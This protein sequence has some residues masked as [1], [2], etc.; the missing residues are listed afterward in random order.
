MER[1]LIVCPHCNAE[2]LPAEIYM[3][4]S[5]LGRPYDIIK[6]SQGKII[7]FSGNS[8]EETESYI[9]DYCNKSFETKFDIDFNT[10]AGIIE[11]F[12]D[13]YVRPV[14]KSFILKET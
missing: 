10:T 2:Y 3:P 4:K 8:I 14:S 6:N 11:F 7:S 5:L 1:K 9:C 13:D 12:N